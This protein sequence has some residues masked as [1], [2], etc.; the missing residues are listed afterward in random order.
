MRRT[1][2]DVDGVVQKTRFEQRFFKVVVR[3]AAIIRDD[4][5]PTRVPHG[6]RRDGDRAAAAHR[7]RSIRSDHQ[8]RPRPRPGP[9]SRS[10]RRRRDRRWTHPGNPAGD[11]GGGGGRRPRRAGQ[12]RHPGVDRSARPR[13]HAGHDAGDAAARW[14]HVDGRWRIGRVGQYRRAGARRAGGAEPRPHLSERGAD[15][16]GRRRRADEH[17]G[18]GRAHRPPCDGTAPRVDRR[19]Q[20]P[21][22]RDCCRRSRSRSRYAAPARW[23]GRCR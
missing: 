9:S 13:G 18:G 16:R 7:R 5:D 6:G 11:R 2:I 23:P 17:R 1:C 20:G 8:G 19:R 14:H 4:G 15:R 3:V 22:V 12:D 21:A 10:C